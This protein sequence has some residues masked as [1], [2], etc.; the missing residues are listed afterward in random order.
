MGWGNFMVRM[1]KGV[2][3][4]KVL[5]ALFGEVEVKTPDARTIYLIKSPMLGPQSMPLYAIDS[6][7][8]VM[9]REEK[10]KFVIPMKSAK[11]FADRIG[12]AWKQVE[13][14]AAAVGFD[15]S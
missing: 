6:R 9:V 13:R 8:L 10:E 14:S 4:L 12:P 11:T 2:D 3:W 7:T 1:K 5:K 15:N